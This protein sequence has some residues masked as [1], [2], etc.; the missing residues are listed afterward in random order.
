MIYQML[1]GDTPFRADTPAA[2]LMAH[3]HQ[4]LPLPTSIN[5]DI[6]PRLEATMLKALAKEPND[7]FQ[8][9]GDL[10]QALSIAAGLAVESAPRQ[11]GADSDPRGH[12]RCVPSRSVRSRRAATRHGREGPADVGRAGSGRSRRA[13]PTSVAADWRRRDRRGRGV[14]CDRRVLRAIGR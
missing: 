6:G 8:S 5:P 4:P 9:G 1:L 2:T 13:T 3:I 11:Q 12:R 7:R 10:I 14:G